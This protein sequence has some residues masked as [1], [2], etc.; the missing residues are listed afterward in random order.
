METTIKKTKIAESE[1][2]ISPENI[3]KIGMGFWASKTV[4]TAVGLKLFTHLAEK[5]LTGREIKSKLNLH[6]RSYLDFLD[7]LTALGFLNRE[8]VGEDA[9][10]YNTEETELFLDKNKPSYIGGMLEMC[11]TR[12]YKAWDTLED[13]LR[14]GLPQNE[15]KESNS[16]N[17]FYD[18]YSNPDALAEFQNAMAGLQAGA[19]ISFVNQFDLSNYST[20]CDVGGGNGAFSIHIA[21]KNPRIKCINFDLK[22]VET[23]AKKKIE[24]ANLSDRIKTASGDFFSNPLPKADVIVMGNVLHDWNDDEKIQLI[25]KAYQALPDGGAFVCIENIIDNERKK[26]AF[27]LLMSLNMLVETRGGSDFTFNDFDSW[28][29]MVGFKKTDWIQLAGPTSAA[30][31]Y[32]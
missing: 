16:K 2:H 24:K 20:L 23:E 26:N 15:L 9:V 7:S 18:F 14:T 10:Y 27:G 5:P 3:L 28:V 31:A 22:E 1:K 17:Q 29:H 32:K 21:A 30:V 12:L 11:N 25:K 13:G 19:F 8:S 6:E 4:L